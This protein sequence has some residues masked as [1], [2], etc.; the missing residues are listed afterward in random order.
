[1]NWCTGI[2]STAVTPSF[3]RCSIIAGWPSPAYVPAHLQRDVLVQE[4][5]ALDVGLVDDGL[6]VRPA[7]RAVGAPV[8]VRVDHDR[9]R[10]ERRR[11][12]VV[13][14]VLVVEVVREQRRV[15]VHPAVD[16]LRVRVEQQLARVA[17]QP[18][19]RVRRARARG[20]RTAGRGRRWAGSR[21]RRSRPP[22]AARS[23][24][25]RPAPSNRHS[26]T[27]CAT[28]EKSEKLVPIPSYV[29]PSGYDDPGHTCIRSSIPDPR[30]FP[31]KAE[32]NAPRRSCPWDL[33]RSPG[34]CGAGHRDPPE[35]P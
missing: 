1:M 30:S 34:R 6:V 19:A 29:A 7:R 17:A 4:G 20:S 3:C 9:L 26:S 31:G 8:E 18:G 12:V 21:A 2:S 24:S 5:Q 10:Q 16:G 28:S 33:S 15:P 13:R 35:R 11:V 23:W 32:P 14:P 27:F 22:P 25:P